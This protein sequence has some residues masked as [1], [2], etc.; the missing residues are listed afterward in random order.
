MPSGLTSLATRNTELAT[1][2]VAIARCMPMQHMYGALRLRDH[3][4]RWPYLQGPRGA[5]Q[6]GRRPR[7]AR[8]SAHEFSSR[9]DQIW[10]IL[11]RFRAMVGRMRPG[12]RA[13]FGRLGF[14]R[15]RATSFGAG[16]CE[17]SN[18]T[19]LAWLRCKNTSAQPR[20]TRDAHEA[21]LSN[22]GVRGAPRGFAEP[23]T[24]VGGAP[25]GR[26]GGPEPGRPRGRRSDPRAT[27]G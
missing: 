8:S 27:C 9:S 2:A 15:L 25:R 12:N 20:A 21:M 17:I 13:K 7:P 1:T 5:A 6:R 26:R 3:A 14:A 18:P 10:A 24:G 23:P 11:D 16:S 22:Q 19:P 4:E